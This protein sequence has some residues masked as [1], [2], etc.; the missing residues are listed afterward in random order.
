[1]RLAKRARTKYNKGRRRVKQVKIGGR[2]IVKYILEIDDINN[3]KIVP[4]LNYI[5]I[6]IMVL[7]NVCKI[8][9]VDTLGLKNA[10]KP[11]KKKKDVQRAIITQK[12]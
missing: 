6:K 8:I 7:E 11:S 9:L 4:N 12:F 3:I 1:L 5:N 10:G 2:K